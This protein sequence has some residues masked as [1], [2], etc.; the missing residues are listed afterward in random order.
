VIDIQVIRLSK[1]IFPRD[2]QGHPGMPRDA[3]GCAGEVSGKRREA[4]GKRQGSAREAPGKHQGSTRES[5]DPTR[6][7]PGSI[8]GYWGNLGLSIYPRI[9]RLPRLSEVPGNTSGC[10]G[11]GEI[12][13]L[14][15]VYIGIPW[16]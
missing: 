13:G 1:S 14:P 9:P 8:Q 12:P 11:K 6:Q 10:L 16:L 2:T 3:Q 4:P 15:Q 5:Q 7:V